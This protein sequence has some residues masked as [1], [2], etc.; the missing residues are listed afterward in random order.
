MPLPGSLDTSEE[1]LHVARLMGSTPFLL[2]TSAYHMRRAM[3]L[4]QRAG[5]QPIAAPTGY[6]ARNRRLGWDMVVP[7]SNAL[8]RTERALHEYQGLLAIALD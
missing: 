7:S 4:M 1:A 6:L 2:V 5:A 3:K 8:R